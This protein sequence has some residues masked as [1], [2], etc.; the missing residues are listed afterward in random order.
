M[1]K[2][3]I[4]RKIQSK[5]LL[6]KTKSVYKLKMVDAN[7]FENNILCLEECILTF[8]YISNDIFTSTHISQCHM[9]FTL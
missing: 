6:R 2:I 9:L 7:I 5:I 3:F 8:T 1:N 4:Y